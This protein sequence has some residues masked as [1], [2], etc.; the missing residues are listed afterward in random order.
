MSTRLLRAAVEGLAGTDIRVP[1][2]LD[3]GIP[4]PPFAAVTVETSGTASTNPMGFRSLFYQASRT[5]VPIA[6]LWS[7]A[8]KR[9][10]S[11][12]SLC[13]GSYRKFRVPLSDG[14][15][16]LV[17]KA[18]ELAESLEGKNQ[19][20]EGK[21]QIASSVTAPVGCSCFSGFLI[22]GER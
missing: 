13:S 1:R 9:Q 3:A 7:S 10:Y 16:L 12:K 15:R 2:A 22:L 19:S 18:F 14:H 8:R 11:M 17:P 20:L 6:E 4:G 21:N 5:V